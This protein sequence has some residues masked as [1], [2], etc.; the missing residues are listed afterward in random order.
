MAAS[1]TE[2]V[3]KEPGNLVKAEESPYAFRQ[4]L[5]EKDNSSFMVL[6]ELGIMLGNN[7]C[8]V[9]DASRC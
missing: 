3:L 7:L 8:E 5:S 4:F 1:R 6:L 2:R 9:A